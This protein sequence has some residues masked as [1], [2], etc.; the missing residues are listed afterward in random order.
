MG[1]T[2]T[3]MPAD[4][5]IPP[6]ATDGELRRLTL[7]ALALGGELD[8]S[9]PGEAVARRVRSLV[10]HAEVEVIP[11]CKYCPPTAPPF[12]AW[13]AGRVGASLSR[14]GWS[15]RRG[16]LGVRRP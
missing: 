4:L 7:P 10:P 15:A 2:L 16:L 6:L 3:D 12:R 8:I 14:T 1:D 11:G 13:L 9:F 5:R